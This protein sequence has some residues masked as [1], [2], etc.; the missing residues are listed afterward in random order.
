MD[1]HSLVMDAGLRRLDAY[2]DVCQDV[3]SCTMQASDPGS[4]AC[5]VCGHVIIL[6]KPLGS[7]YTL[8]DQHVIEVH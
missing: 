1:P 5:V 7:K 3:R 8:P 4:C 2:C 6:M